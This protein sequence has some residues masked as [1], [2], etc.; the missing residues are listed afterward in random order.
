M[1]DA[2]FWA[3]IVGLALTV[4]AYRPFRW[5]PFGVSGFFASWLTMELAPQLLAIHVAT[6]PTLDRKSVV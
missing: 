2:F 3:S 4:N 1:S 6:V 5:T